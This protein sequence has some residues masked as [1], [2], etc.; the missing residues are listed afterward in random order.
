MWFVA[1]YRQNS[2]MRDKSLEDGSTVMHI[3]RETNSTAADELAKYKLVKA[4]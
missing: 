4:P 3:H 1:F 2:N